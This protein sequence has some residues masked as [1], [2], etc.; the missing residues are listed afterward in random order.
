MKHLKKLL[1]IVITIGFLVIIKDSIQH[2]KAEIH[3][4]NGFIKKERGYPKLA[5]NDFKAA[6]NLVGWETH[7][8]LQLA[9]SYEASAAK[10]PNEYTHFMSKAI[11]EYNTLIQSDP[12]NPWFKA[13][14]GLIYH[15]LYKKEPNNQTYKTLA[16]DFAKAATDSDPKNPLFTLHYGHLLYTYNQL[17][18]AKSYYLKTIKY[19]PDI[20]EAHF[21]L[22]A[23]YNQQ[24]N[25][26]GAIT[27]HKIVTDQ[28]LKLESLYRIT[29]KKIPKLKLKNFKMLE[30]PLPDIT[31]KQKKLDDAFD[32][33][34]LIPVSVEKY[35]LMAEY[36]SEANQIATAISL[37][38]Q[39]NQRLNTDNYTQKIQQLSK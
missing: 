10:F 39:L 27:H 1:F 29:K 2:I 15:E 8:R 11:K 9:K 14:I 25:A 38:K 16:H 34:N 30:L 28:L 33:I 6:V 35:E 19:D 12:I 13:R 32:M 23:I 17:E 36:Y 4:R 24:N 37:Y 22:A 7:Y 3:H 21:N 26:M 31:L 18:K 5:N 20:T